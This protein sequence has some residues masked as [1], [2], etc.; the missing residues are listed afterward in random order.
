MG[1]TENLKKQADQFLD[2]LY[3]TSEGSP[4][5]VNGRS[6]IE[7]IGME[8]QIGLKVMEYLEG[9]NLLEV[10][11]R[12]MGNYP[13]ALENIRITKNG[14]EHVE[15]LRDAKGGIPLFYTEP[16]ENKSDDEL[17]S[18]IAKLNRRLGEIDSGSRVHNLAKEKIAQAKY[19]LERR[20]A[21]RNRRRANW[22][23]GV[24]IGTFVVSITVSILLSVLVD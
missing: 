8:V 22:A 2:Q 24:A 4:K 12:S 5:I 10:L 14:M 15:R 6:V 3:E 13:A 23:L 20:G 19:A 7:A 16:L 18:F 17:V 11:A 21:V 1:E 9:R